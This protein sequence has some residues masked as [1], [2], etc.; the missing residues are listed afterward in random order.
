MQSFTIPSS[1]SPGS[2][3]SAFCFSGFAQSGYFTERELYHMWPFVLAFFHL[4]SCFQGSFIL[5]DILILCFS[6]WLNNI[7]SYKYTIS[8]LSVI[9]ERNG[10]PLQ[11]SCLE[12]PRD[13]GAWWAT[14]YGVVQSRTQLKRLRSSSNVLQWADNEAQG[15][16]HHLRPSWF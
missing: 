11:C 13:G 12:N 8:H 7:P 5:Q 14:I 9:G 4:T 2:H 3:S 16:I 6:S 1:P 10:N 15:I